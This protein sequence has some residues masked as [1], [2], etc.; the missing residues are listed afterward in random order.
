MG[1]TVGQAKSVAQGRGHVGFVRKIR[2]GICDRV[3]FRMDQKCRPAFRAGTH[4]FNALLSFAPSFD[5]HVFELFVQEF[6]ARLFP[7]RVGDFDK[8]RK[9]AGR[10]E[11]VDLAVVNASKQTL[12]RL[13]RICAMRKDFGE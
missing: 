1:E 6:L 5:D 3:G 12:Y 13:G 10:L 8:I 7:S 4:E 9:H 11:A 2:T